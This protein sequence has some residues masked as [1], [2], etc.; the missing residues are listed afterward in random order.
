M[1]RMYSENQVI[2][3]IREYAPE[4]TP[5]DIQAMF[6]EGEV[7]LTGKYVRIMTHQVATF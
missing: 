4:V 1:R 6:D 7:S 2:E 5:E 3:M